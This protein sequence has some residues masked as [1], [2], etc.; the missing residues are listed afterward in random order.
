MRPEWNLAHF[1]LYSHGLN[2]QVMDCH[3][4]ATDL[5]KLHRSAIQRQDHRFTVPN[6]FTGRHSLPTPTDHLKNPQDTQHH[7][8]TCKKFTSHIHQPLFHRDRTT[9]NQL[10]IIMEHPAR[11]RRVIRQV[12][13][14][15]TTKPLFHF[16]ILI[17]RRR[18]I[19]LFIQL[20]R[21]NRTMFRRLP[22]IQF[23]HLRL[24]AIMLTIQPIHHQLVNPITQPIQLTLPIHLQQ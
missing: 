11:F 14:N 24:R 22:Q 16:P 23:I 19:Q 4:K 18:L 1:F 21:V 12:L 6:R 15:P 7:H 8:I 10:V 3:P 17:T 9:A 13:A 20:D 2:V 5:L